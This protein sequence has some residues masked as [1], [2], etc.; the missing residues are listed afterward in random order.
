[1][2]WLAVFNGNSNL[3][4]SHL[5][6]FQNTSYSSCHSGKI[7]SF[8]FYFFKKSHFANRELVLMWKRPAEQCPIRAA[9]I[10]RLSAELEQR[11]VANPQ[12]R[13]GPMK[14]IKL[15]TSGSSHLSLLFGLTLPFLSVSLL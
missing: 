11:K 5:G 7:M 8:F 4:I 10:D 12:T 15:T 13:L 6:S 9:D 2:G 14:S 1:M 3:P